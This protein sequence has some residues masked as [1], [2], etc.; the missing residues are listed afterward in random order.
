MMMC[1]FDNVVCASMQS[2]LLL[3][4]PG[5]AFAARFTA[6]P[7]NIQPG[8]ANFADWIP[9]IKSPRCRLL[10]SW[11]DNACTCIRRENRAPVHRL[12]NE[13]ADERESENYAKLRI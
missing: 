3:D 8:P 1:R 5:T 6:V 9:L 4:V 11:P 13:Q 10:R 12:D 2:N 7:K